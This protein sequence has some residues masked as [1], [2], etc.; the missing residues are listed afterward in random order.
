M[1]RKTSFLALG[2]IWVLCSQGSLLKNGDFEIGTLP[3]ADGWTMCPHYRVEEGAGRNGSRGLIVE[4]SDPNAM[5]GEFCG[6]FVEAK[7]GFK[8]RFSGWVKCEN[9]TG[10]AKDTGI[11]ARV[12]VLVFVFDAKGKGLGEYYTEFKAGTVSD[13]TRIEGE[14]PTLPPTAAR[15]QVNPFVWHNATGRAW[16][17]DISI[18]KIEAVPVRGLYSSSYRDI[19]WD[20]FVKFSAVLGIDTAVMP[21][22]VLTAEFVY[23]TGNYTCKRVPAESFTA[24]LAQATVPV[25]NLPMGKYPVSFELRRKDG[26]KLISE[27]PLM[28]TRTAAPPKRKV[29]IDSRNRLIVGGRPFFPLGFYGTKIDE[30]YISNMDGTP[31]NCY[32]PYRYL[33]TNEFNIAAK[34]GLWIIANMKDF[35]PG[36]GGT[37]CCKVLETNGEADRGL[38]CRFHALKDYPKL[39]CW[40]MNDE[41]SVEQI[42]RLARQYRYVRDND[43]DHPAWAVLFQHDQVRE[44]MGTCD[45]VGNDDYPIGLR[46]IETVSRYARDTVEGFLGGPCWHV[47]QAINWKHYLKTGNTENFRMPTLE[48]AR[49]MSWQYIANGGN[50]LIYYTFER[51]IDEGGR[52][53][54]NYCTVAH[55]VKSLEGILLAEPAPNA[56]GYPPLMSGRAW[57]LDG[58]TYLL[59]VNENET[60][61]SADL[62][63]PS[64]FVSV[65]AMNTLPSKSRFALSGEKLHVE[66][67]PIDV[68]MLE[69]DPDAHTGEPREAI[70]DKS[71]AERRDP[72][73]E[74]GPF[75]DYWWQNRFHNH[76]R[77]IANMKGG[78]VDLVLI[79]DSVTH[80]WESKHSA[81]WAAL[82]NRYS[83]INLGY[84]GDRTQDV[85]WRV[86]N[87]EL[88]GYRA[89]VVILMIG[90]N[91]NAARDSR[92][93][94]VA[95][96]VERILEVIREKQPQAK[97][98]LLPIFP[99]GSKAEWT[100]KY[101]AEAHRRNL[102]TNPHLHKL[103][104]GKR[105]FWLDFNSRL[106]DAD[107][108]VP[109]DIMND[110]IH[111][112]DK[113]Y[114]IWMEALSP[115]LDKFL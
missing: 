112:T 109:Y 76:L 41:S 98:I 12:L 1:K 38:I 23:S 58:R 22:D 64:R 57:T 6:Q 32:M 5:S 13:W 26:R 74:A 92:P 53:W 15:L 7:P 8:Y 49:S 103:A 80:F 39:L 95:R 84:G 34:H 83:A 11:K 60:P 43:P 111:P 97:V 85:L 115:L 14:T 54:E 62:T 35:I 3:G 47:P 66:M 63:L 45:V 73:L 24:T 107:G 46:P 55:E 99:R 40:Y 102:A 25:S 100:I 21:L 104:D 18:E 96:G 87:G 110:A 59:V 77:Q 106:A 65:K 50:G 19:A 51:L 20:G 75:G 105:V 61:R 69:L 16:F 27:V 70:P 88:D 36:K 72:T 9:V 30:K 31:F 56:T 68:V 81:S 42:E 48:E 29:W 17:D 2:A 93:E 86:M 10:H 91:N 90:T 79:G 67:G 28:F 101:H 113:G 71:H 78:T 114:A 52:Y 89:K 108:H 94:N 44:Y 37:P 33:G 4:N 82:T